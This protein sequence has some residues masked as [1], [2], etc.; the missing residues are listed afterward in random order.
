MWL[1]IIKN[2]LHVV[3][4]FLNGIII[5][6]Y[7]FFCILTL[8]SAISIGAGTILYDDVM[9]YLVLFVA[10]RGRFISVNVMFFTQRTRDGS[11]TLCVLKR[12][13]MRGSM[14]GTSECYEVGND[15]Q[16]YKSWQ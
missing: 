2:V 11:R 3:E 9:V 8:S 14:A 12:L 5:I 4:Y 16:V 7:L 6:Y 10:D 15:I 13:Y 1:L